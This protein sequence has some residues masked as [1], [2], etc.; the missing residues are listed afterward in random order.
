[1]SSTN[2]NNDT[3]ALMCSSDSHLK[4]FEKDEPLLKPNLK[5][6]VLF[7]IQY[8]DIFRFYKQGEAS[9]WKTEEV[10]LDAD[11]HDFETKL[12][13][14]E[15]Y[16]VK[17]V[18]AFFSSSDGIVGEN[19]INNFANAVQIPEARQFYAMQTFIEAVHAEMYSELIDNFISDADEKY[20]LF[21]AIENIPAIAKKAQWAYKWLVNQEVS[22]AHR[23]IAFACVEGIF[24]SGSFAAIFW[25]KK[26]GLMPGLC[27]SNEFISRDEGLHTD[28]A[29]LLYS[30][31]QKKLKNDTI[32]AIVKEA[33]ELEI[34]FL[35]EALPVSLI[36][37]NQ[38]LM[39][40]YIQ[41]VADRLLVSLKVPKLYNVSNPF[42]FMENI[43]MEGKQNFF[44]GS[45]SVYQKAGIMSS[46]KDGKGSNHKFD[47]ACDF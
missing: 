46:L 20:Q 4:D 45:S 37:M 28:F 30:H 39:A 36:G 12:T 5:R 40:Q 27:L 9:I 31:L 26:R 21:N 44:E 13:D 11:K 15:R 29:C 38:K 33:V 2:A 19:L 25:L 3:T 42:D 24:F 6:F 10:P 16:F 7:P 18:L 14:N 34:E 8:P 22:F 32:H 35:T 1:M 41:F 47:L 43:S 23:L 17:H